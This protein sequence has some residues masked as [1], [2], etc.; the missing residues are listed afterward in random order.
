MKL[1]YGTKTAWTGELICDLIWLC[2][3]NYYP[4]DPL[5]VYAN[6][7][8]NLKAALNMAAEGILTKNSKRNY[9]YTIETYFHS[10]CKLSP[11]SEEKF[12]NWGQFVLK[13]RIP[14]GKSGFYTVDLKHE[15]SSRFNSLVLELGCHGSWEDIRLCRK[16]SKIMTWKQDILVRWL[17]RW[18]WEILRQPVAAEGQVMCLGEFL[19]TEL[20]QNCGDEAGRNATLDEIQ[21]RGQR[22]LMS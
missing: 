11:N 19:A 10:I 5:M 1:Y 3:D 7:Y 18:N 21:D 2:G 16:A 22:W 4:N 20:F 13:G 9:R 14:F 12:W 8:N 15:S 17:A 6:Y